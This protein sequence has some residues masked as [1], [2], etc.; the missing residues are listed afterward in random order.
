MPEG[1]GEVAQLPSKSSLSR[2]ESGRKPVFRMSKTEANFLR[3]YTI[4][5]Y[6]HREKTQKRNSESKLLQEPERSMSINL[7]ASRVIRSRRQTG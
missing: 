7:T 3:P 5:I 2:L 1:G 6:I 4:Y